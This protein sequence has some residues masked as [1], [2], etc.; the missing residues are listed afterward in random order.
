ML[1]RSR[2]H[3]DLRSLGGRCRAPA[4]RDGSR[5]GR[6][7]CRRARASPARSLRSGRTCRSDRRSRRTSQGHGARA[8][9]FTNWIDGGSFQGPSSNVS[10]MSRTLVGPWKTTSG[11][12]ATQPTS[13]GTC[14]LRTVCRQGSVLLHGAGGVHSAQRARHLPAQRRGTGFRRSAGRNAALRLSLVGRLIGRR[15]H[16]PCPARR[17]HDQPRPGAPTRHDAHGR[18]QRSARSD[19]RAAGTAKRRLA[20]E[21]RRPRTAGRASL[22]RRGP[23]PAGA[24]RR[25]TIGVRPPRST[26]PAVLAPTPAA[27]CAQRACQHE[28]HDRHDHRHR[29]HASPRIHSRAVPEPV[30]IVGGTGALGFGL[31]LRLGRARRPDRDRVARRRPRAPSSAAGAG[32]RSP[33]ARSPGSS[34]RRR[35]SKPRS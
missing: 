29:P 21:R 25:P 26:A 28:H 11:P 32:Q 24:A 31:A 4:C 13:L 3:R 23:A 35:S 16:S 1:D 22:S 7:S 33:T 20:P 15:D 19:A 8:S 6:R 30:C 14:S 12:L 27:A 2:C 10:A 34:T 5:C 9:S 17:L 18:V